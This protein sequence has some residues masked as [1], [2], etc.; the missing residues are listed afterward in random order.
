MFNSL[1]NNKKY[2]YRYSSSGEEEDEENAPL[3]YY[4]SLSGS[5][6]RKKMKK[7]NVAVIIKKWSKCRL[8]KCIGFFI[9]CIIM[10]GLFLILILASPL[11]L[12]QVTSIGNV[13]GTQKQLI[14]D[15]HVKAR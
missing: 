3:L 7:Q 13:L 2:H 12:I 11:D 9:C 6:V 5:Y 14:F 15:L 8:I 1:T 4:S 10:C